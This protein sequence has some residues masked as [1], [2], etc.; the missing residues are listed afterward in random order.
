MIKPGYSLVVVAPPRGIF[1]FFFIYLFGNEKY[2][3][4]GLWEILSHQAADLHT[5]FYL[6]FEE[7]KHK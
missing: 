1:L 4:K 3:N 2:K 7:T 6:I 5:D